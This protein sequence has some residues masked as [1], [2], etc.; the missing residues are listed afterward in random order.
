MPYSSP[1]NIDAISTSSTVI[2]VSWIKVNEIDQNGVITMYEVVYLGEFDLTNRSVFTLDGD[3]LTVNITGVEEF[4][5]YNISV[6]A[7]TSVGPGPYSQV[8][9]ELTMEDGELV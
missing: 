7:Y 6:R 3:T 4:A 1:R 5:E 2:H 8:Q 9:M